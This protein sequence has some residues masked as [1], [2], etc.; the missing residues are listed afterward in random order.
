M[1]KVKALLGDYPMTRAIK[2]GDAVMPGFSFDFLPGKPV[3]YFRGFMQDFDIDIAEVPI[4][5]YL[6]AHDRGLP[7]VL[8]PAIVLGGSQHGYL[9]R[10]AESQI[11]TPA[12]LAGKRVGVRSYSVTTVT[13]IRDILQREHGVDPGSIEWVTFEPPHIAPRQALPNVTMAPP[14][15]SAEG[16]LAAGDLDAAVLRVVPEGGRFVPVIA[17]AEQRGLDWQRAESGVQINHMVA[18]PQAFAEHHP[19]AVH[20]FMTALQISAA[21]EGEAGSIGQESIRHSLELS[22]DCARRQGI[23]GRSPSV[24]SLLFHQDRD[25][26]GPGLANQYDFNKGERQ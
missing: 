23:I 26:P 7:L 24:E 16:M 8:L 20:G 5:T 19:N 4:M 17:E 22:I 12:D 6:M 15:A 13:W 9:F 1:N 10:P 3:S 2:S 21:A 11:A 25:F 14:G 18:V